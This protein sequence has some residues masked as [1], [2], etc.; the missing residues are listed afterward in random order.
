MFRRTSPYLL[1]AAWFACGPGMA[2]AAQ[3]EAGVKERTSSKKARAGAEKPYG[4]PGDPRKV[5][6]VI[7][8]DMSDTM[9]FF[10]SSFSVKRG[11]TVR[12]QLRNGGQLPHEMVIGTMDELKQHAALMKKHPDM[13]HTQAHAAHVLPG[14]TARMVWQF[15]KPG[16]FHYACL[17]PG[18]FDAGMIGTIVVR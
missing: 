1:I 17:V 4:R 3:S 13:M 16:E 2:A 18:H 8:I 7:A 6:R 12:F 15:T 9:Q 11:D 5:K 14:E 10:P